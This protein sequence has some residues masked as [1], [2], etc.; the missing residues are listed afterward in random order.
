MLDKALQRRLQIS[1]QKQVC[2]FSPKVRKSMADYFLSE[3]SNNI[4]FE[5]ISRKDKPWATLAQV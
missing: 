4:K 5:E 3:I 1:Q 2:W